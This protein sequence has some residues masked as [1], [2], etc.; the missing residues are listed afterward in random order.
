MVQSD[1]PR[2][3]RFQVADGQLKGLSH[4][5]RDPASTSLCAAI[6]ASLVPD[7]NSDGHRTMVM[8]TLTAR[9]DR[10]ATVT[11]VRT[12]MA[13]ARTRPMW[14]A[15]RAERPDCPLLAIDIHRSFSHREEPG[16]RRSD[17]SGT[18]TLL[19]APRVEPS[20]GFRAQALAKAAEGFAP[21][22]PQ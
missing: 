21:P 10:G 17:E 15:R 1:R 6:H 20:E 9:I 7:T 19:A 11:A 12:R 14:R 8:S 2:V 5:G 3:Q 13:G 4:D 18:G 16:S 22:S